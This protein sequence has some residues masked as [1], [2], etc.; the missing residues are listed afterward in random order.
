[1]EK[2]DIGVL[3]LWPGCNYGS[4]ATY[5]ALNQV[6][7]SMGK[8]VLM[9]DKPI[10][11]NRDI[12]LKMTH[13]RRFAMEHYNISEQYRP[14]ELYKLNQICDAFV[15]GS[16]QVWNYGISKNFG[17]IF[18]FDFVEEEK[19]KIAY[20][21]SF[22]HGVDFAPPEERKVIA[23]YMAKIDGI[24]VREADGVRLCRD[25]YGIKAEQVL[26]PVFLADPQI[27]Q[28]IIEKSTAHETE[29]FLAAYI[30]D[31]TPE[32]REAILHLSQ[33]LG[34]I[35]IINLLD[36]MPGTFEKNR[37]LT[38]LPN[39]IE[40]LQV[41]DWLYYLS[42]AEYV[43]TD[44]CHGASFAI[45]FNKN[46]TAITNK[47]RGFSRFKSLF[48][49]FEI[50]SHLVT[51]PKMIIDNEKLLENINY[52]FIGK[53]LSSER[54]RC[55]KWLSDILNRPKKP[56]EIL[57]RENRIGEV[58]ASSEHNTANRSLPEPEMSND[59]KR[60][61]MLVTLLRDYGIKHVVLS[62]GSRNL[63]LVRL[64]EGNS[65]FKTY[66]VI[67]ERSAGFYAMGIA[68]KLKEPVAMCCTSGTAASNYLTSI[69]EAYYQHV[70]LVVITADRYPC[71]LGQ[72]EDQTIPQ[73][74]MYEKVCKRSVTL[75]VNTGY[76]GDWEARRLVC[77]ALLEM[78][79]HGNGPVHINIPIASIERPIPP[80]EALRLNRKYLKI[81]RITLGDTQR[82]WRSKISRLSGMK[83]IMVLYGQEHPLA[84]EEQELVER[85]SKKFHCVII[86]DHLSNFRCSNS[87][88]SLSVLRNVNQEMFDRDLA[89]DILITVGG[90]RMLNDPSLPKIRAQKHPF[91]HWRVAEDGA[92][93]DTYRRLTNIFECSSR[94]FF[95]RFV[96]SDVEC[97][98]SDSY[99][100]MWR[101]AEAQYETPTTK[102][103]S[104]L[105]V[106]EQTV[107]NLPDN[108]CVHYGIG[109]TIMFANRFPIKS[110]VEVFCNMGTNGI[111]GSASTF[112]GHVVVSDNLCFLII[113]DLSFFYDMN[114]VWSKPLRGNIRIMMCNNVGTDLLRH[115]GS[116]SITHEH[117]AVAREWVKSLGFTYLCSRNKEEF[118]SNLKRFVSSEDTPMFFEAFTRFD[119]G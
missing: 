106:V 91:G 82:I 79:H 56:A 70:P 51:D 7:T 102:E 30:L 80:A 43:I 103:Y 33:K 53:K 34:G 112:M 85:F 12:E 17:K 104:Q 3:G 84:P 76:L 108:C 25:E 19:K 66:S 97:N 92:I 40:N 63:N 10:L 45:I 9:I 110:T 31:P 54:N 116:P 37:Q 94:Q 8:S 21:V 55:Y 44:S 28:P 115:L 58:D 118:D 73:V 48:D 64:F 100:E 101:S 57:K 29:P 96:N 67:D 60:C 105:Y 15:I 72:N 18:Y 52:E 35:K 99:I 47:R 11:S 109:N 90:R 5:Y 27:Y 23:E 22:G 107:R 65:C 77:D 46:L 14:N 38:D 50:Q 39:C 49:L 75:P 1:M 61:K 2:Y 74:N 93:A 117:N 42:H 16:D 95:E 98:N 13:S 88:M 68:L 81:E 20:A 119:K 62:A 87:V 69:T 113:S 71:L 114:S 111:D 41:E 32:K 26:D 36:G 24:S 78:T 6:L 86:T 4:V 89:P 59:F 83:R